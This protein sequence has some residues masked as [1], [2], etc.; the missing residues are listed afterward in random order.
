MYNEN[1]N[2][3]VEIYSEK[4][5]NKSIEISQFLD[6]YNGNE[7]QRNEL[8]KIRKELNI[9]HREVKIYPEEKKFEEWDD[10]IT[11]ADGLLIRTGIGLH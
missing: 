2:I 7:D 5:L 3:K 8:D 10:L 11:A 1:M 4:L 6:H 9:A